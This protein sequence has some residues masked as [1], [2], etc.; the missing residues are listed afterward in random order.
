MYVA[1]ASAGS[2][3]PTPIK[4]VSGKK[5]YLRFHSDRPLTLRWLG[6]LGQA[7]EWLKEEKRNE[8]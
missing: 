4:P 7:E 8:H 2:I 6:D 3:P 5:Q 1:S